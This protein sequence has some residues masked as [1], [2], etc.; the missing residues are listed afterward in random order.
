MWWEYHNNIEHKSLL[1]TTMTD[2]SVCTEVTC[3]KYN[4]GTDWQHTLYYS[5]IL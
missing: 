5:M 3:C 2:F 1:S 4:F